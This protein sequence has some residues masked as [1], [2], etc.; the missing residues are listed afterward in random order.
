MPL[1]VVVVLVVTA[2]ALRRG[3]WDTALLL[4]LFN[5]LMNLYPV[6]SMRHIRARGRSLQPLA[7]P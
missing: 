1:I 4:L 6:F 7:A 5:V 3:R 2:A